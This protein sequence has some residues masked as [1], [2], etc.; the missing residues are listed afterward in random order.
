M[1]GEALLNRPVWNALSGAQNH[2]SFGN[3]VARRFAPQYGPLTAA[4]DY[5]E[6]GFAALRDLEIGETGLWVF[7][8]FIPVNPIGFEILLCVPC[9]QMIAYEATDAP[10]ELD[11]I[12]L[13]DYDAP[14]M[15]ALA[16]LTRPGPFSTHTHQLGQFIGFK[17]NGK[18]VAMAGERMKLAGFAE[19]SGVCT[20]PD[21]RGRGHAKALSQIIT[22]RIIARGEKPF[23]HTYQGNDVAINLYQSL[24]YQA[25]ATVHL[26]VLKPAW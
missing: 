10:L 3:N 26:T 25:R 18:L 2:L 9:V 19:L 6:D 14:E 22:N 17:A 12:E 1:R 21:Y 23:L 24:G 11:M 13:N 7:D 20:H 15:L 5:S 16:E 8:E 4:I